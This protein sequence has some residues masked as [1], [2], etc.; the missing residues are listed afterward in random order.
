MTATKSAYTGHHVHWKVQHDQ[1]DI[2][3]VACDRANESVNSLS[4]AVLLELSDIIGYAEKN[5]LQG[6][7]ITS[8]KKSGFIVGADI[9]EF[10]KFTEAAEVTER[11][12]AGHAVLDRLEKLSCATV[13]AV[14]GFCLGGGLELALACDY[15]VAMNNDNTRIGL[16]EV[17]LGIYPGLGGTVRLTERV[18]GMAGMQL[19]LTGR[20]LRAGAARR[21]GVVDELVSETGSLR[22]AA[23]RAVVKRRKRK[24]LGAAAKLTNSG[25]ARKSLARIMRKQTAAKANP[26][27][28]P[29]PFDLIDLWENYRGD[30]KEMFRQEALGVGRLMVSDTARNLQRIFHLTERMKGL[31]KAD[32][33]K[34]RRVHVIG[35]GVMGGDIAAWC[36]V[37]GMEVTLQ[38]R[39]MKYIE[40][41]LK[42]ARSL[43]KKRLRKK[44]AI[45]A[46]SSRLIADVEGKGVERADVI[47]EAIFEDRDAK[48]ALFESIEPRMRDNAVLATNTSAIP[49]E[50][51]SS[52]LSNPDR[53]I[54]LH[55]FNPVAKM[56]LVEVV[57][58]PNT[59]AA[60]V[61][62]GNAFCTQI[63]RFPLPTRSS[64]GFLVNRVLAPYLMEAMKMHLEGTEKEV[65]DAAAVQFGMPMGPIEL[66]DIVGLDVCIKV[67]E[68]LSGTEI[69]QERKLLQDMIDQKHLGKKSG[70]GFYTWE[71]GKPVKKSVPTGNAYNEVLGKRLL[72]PFLDECIACHEEG[73]VEDADLLD[74]GI[75]FGTGFAPFHG[76]PMKYLEARNAAR[77]QRR[78]VAA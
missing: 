52:V 15:I 34:V 54:G 45:T 17:K 66:A 47:I 7:V 24:P 73:V 6:L 30:R 76:G 1:D 46:A 8:A 4:E 59:D 50:E 38:D 61:S 26:D 72:K 19:M 27:H 22:W 10:E 56:Q 78:E 71:K 32:D 75:I 31:G 77:E 36:V 67:A 62:K 28:Y 65:I 69:E 25:P 64:P 55:F 20:M 9:R 68:T 44:P 21:M 13:A 3:W 16:P 74:A 12:L 35:A 29:A 41:A 60:W 57:H 2:L 53:L 42:R 23:R 39:E 11:I 51:L 37:Q 70:Q 58:A 43:F 48:R 14:D 40:P 49:L 33:F 63:N 18:G 5:P